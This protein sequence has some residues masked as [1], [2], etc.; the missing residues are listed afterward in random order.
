MKIDYNADRRRLTSGESEENMQTIKSGE[1]VFE[2]VDKVPC[3]YMIWNIGTNM[4]DGYLPL[5]RLK[6]AQPFQ[7]GREIEVD[8][9]KAIKVDGAQIILDVIG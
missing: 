6:A 4:V 5:C 9:L 3:G 7:G 1:H 2:I 8:T